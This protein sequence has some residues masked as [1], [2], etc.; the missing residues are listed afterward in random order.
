MS[1][2][3]A[4]SL[5]QL[6][7]IKRDATGQPK[8]LPGRNP[9]YPKYAIHNAAA[10]EPSWT[11]AEGGISDKTVN[12]DL[13]HQDGL[14]M[15]NTHTMYGT[16]MSVQSHTAILARGA[17]QPSGPSP[18]RGRRLP[19][20]APTSA[21]GWATTTQTGRT[22]YGEHPRYAAFHVH[23]PGANDRA[24]CVRV[25]TGNTTD[26]LC[27]HSAIRSA[28]QPFTATTTRRAAS[29]RR[30]TGCLPSRRLHARPS[31]SAT[32]CSISSTPPTSKPSTA[33]PC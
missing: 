26:Q 32:S 3:R 31:P 9:L 25:S 19:G 23:L 7:I 24:R 2:P 18:L 29:R 13:M 20:L 12:T 17:A 5:D 16:M 22:T 27:A 33:R 14:V 8:G 6:T 1:D 21:T 28:F 11:A 10:G 30:S 15:D 4:I